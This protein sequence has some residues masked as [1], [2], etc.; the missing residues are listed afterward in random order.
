[1]N[2][3]SKSRTDHAIARAKRSALGRTLC[4][5][6]G[7]QAG[8]IMMEYVILGTLVAAAVVAIVAIFGKD[9]AKG[10]GLMSD[11][12]AKPSAIT[13]TRIT[14]ET[15]EHKTQLSDAQ[16]RQKAVADR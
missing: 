10:L 15:E 6:T 16:E 14:Q 5:L 3:R 2:K 9:I 7:D 4:R 1:M 8:G 11:A 13:T 12:V